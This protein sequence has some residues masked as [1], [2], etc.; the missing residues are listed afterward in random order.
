[1]DLPVHQQPVTECWLKNV[2]DLRWAKDFVDKWSGKSIDRS[3][4]S[5]QIEEDNSDLCVY[6]QVGQCQKSAD[7]CDWQHIKC[8]EYDTCRTEDCRFGHRT[9]VKAKQTLES[10]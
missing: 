2:N 1:M 6:F 3:E 5:C 10:M 8:E 7:H 9:G 4:I